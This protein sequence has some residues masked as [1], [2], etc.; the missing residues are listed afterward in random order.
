[1]K[2]KGKKSQIVSMIGSR[3]NV[4]FVNGGAIY[5]HREDIKE[6]LGTWPNPNLLLESIKSNISIHPYL[7]GLRALGRS[8]QAIY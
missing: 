4:I 8:G 2:G 3:L 6:F 5:F 1:M 7:A